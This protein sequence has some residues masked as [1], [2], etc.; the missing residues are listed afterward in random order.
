MVLFVS[1]FVSNL[2]KHFERFSM[3]LKPNFNDCWMVPGALFLV[4]KSIKNDVGH[5]YGIGTDFV[6]TSNRFVPPSG[7]PKSITNHEK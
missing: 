7:D 2:G 5:R 4:L 3:N 1:F 6:T